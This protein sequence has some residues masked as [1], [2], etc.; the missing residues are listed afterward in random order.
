MIEAWQACATI[1]ATT[2]CCA[3]SSCRIEAAEAP[4]QDQAQRKHFSGYSWLQNPS[5]LRG[6]AR[7][8]TCST[9]PRRKAT[10]S[11]PLN[12]R[13]LHLPGGEFSI[14]AEQHGTGVIII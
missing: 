4:P 1:R 13:Q 5:P 9:A 8:A 7:Y 12:A 11:A 10:L 6:F 3:R 2:P 14:V